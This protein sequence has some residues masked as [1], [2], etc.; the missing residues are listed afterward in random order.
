MQAR[1]SLE[2]AD[3]YVVNIGSH[4]PTSEVLLAAFSLH[5]ISTSAFPF[6]HCFF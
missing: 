5:A 6:P 4:N 3:A 2:A 1:P